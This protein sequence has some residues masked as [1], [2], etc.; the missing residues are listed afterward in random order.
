MDLNSKDIQLQYQGFLNTPQLW[1]SDIIFGLKQLDLPKIDVIPFNESI[2][3]KLRLGK[4]VERFVSNL[5]KQH[6]G[7]KILSEKHHLWRSSVQKALNLQPLVT[8]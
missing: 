2:E 1:K 7:F 6:E 8:I 3:K 4:R 5:L